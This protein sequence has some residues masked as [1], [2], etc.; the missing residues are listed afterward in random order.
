MKF[1]YDDGGRTAA[2]Y[3][4]E[5]GD[6]VCRAVAIVTGLPYQEIYDQLATETGKQRTGKRGK[7]PASARN[8]I[9]TKRKW[10]HDYMTSLNLIW[11]PCMAIGSG[12][13]VHLRDGELP[14]GRLLVSTSRHMTAVIDGVI[15]DIYDP[16]R[17]GRRC[18]YGYY[19][20]NE[21]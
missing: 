9:N 12:C 17:N 1:I 7:R 16:S 5:A 11:T 8:G 2:G 6:C 21:P 19:R 4:G 18:V 15:H 10:F 14:M 13:Q 3:K 20:K